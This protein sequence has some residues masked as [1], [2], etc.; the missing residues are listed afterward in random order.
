MLRLDIEKGKAVYRRSLGACQ[1]GMLHSQSMPY[2]AQ[3]AGEHTCI[4]IYIY[5]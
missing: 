4:Y 5:I 1:L 3:K 2:I